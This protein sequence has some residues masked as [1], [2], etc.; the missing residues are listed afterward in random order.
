MK[1]RLEAD[2]EVGDEAEPH[3]F[4][5]TTALVAPCEQV[6]ECETA[7][8]EARR[9][10]ARLALASGAE[11]IFVVCLRLPNG[12]IRVEAESLGSIQS[13]GDDAD[14]ERAIAE[15]TVRWVSTLEKYIRQYPE[16]YFWFHN[17]WKTKPAEGDV[18]HEQ[19]SA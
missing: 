11:G 10:D 17:R 9:K 14:K 8:V 7:D 4:S 16:H 18:V 2:E 19:N 1:D 15:F 13:S 5:P 12:R 3:S 6:G